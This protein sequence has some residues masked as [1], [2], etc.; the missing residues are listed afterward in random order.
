MTHKTGPEQ[1]VSV[2]EGKAVTVSISLLN[3]YEG[4]PA[5][6]GVGSINVPWAVRCFLALLRGWRCREAEPCQPCQAAPSGAL[7]LNFTIHMLNLQFSA[8]AKL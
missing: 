7:L 2:N 5:N 8:L 6:Q 1:I 4:I 3:K